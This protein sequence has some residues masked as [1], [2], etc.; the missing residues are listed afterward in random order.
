AG[1]S[2]ADDALNSLN[3]LTD[4][5]GYNIRKSFGMQEECVGIGDL[6]VP[7]EKSTLFEDKASKIIANRNTGKML[8]A[9]R[10]ASK[11]FS[12]IKTTKNGGL[13]FSESQYIMKNGNG[14]PIIATI[15]MSGSRSKDFTRAFDEVD[16]PANQRNKI[17]EDY[18]WHHIDDYDEATGKCTMQLVK[19]DAHVATYPHK[20]SCAQYD[21]I[22]GETYNKK[23]KGKTPKEKAADNGFNINETENGGADF[24]KTEYLYVTESGQEA[25]VKI[26]MSGKKSEDAKMLFDNLGISKEE[27]KTLLTENRVFYLD[28]FDPDTGECTIQIV[29]K[30]AYDVVKRYVGAQAQY[31]A[32]TGIKYK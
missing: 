24:A 20:G 1:A 13:D 21:G 9:E 14:D 8:P 26:K 25:T 22:H 3:E 10:A 30:D 2:K 28:D 32:N 18:T 6:Y 19:K 7:P 12:G 27:Q 15:D 11:G 23:Y 17:L 5:V 31:K 4:R 29:D 16:I